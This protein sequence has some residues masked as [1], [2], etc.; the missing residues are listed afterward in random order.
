MINKVTVNKRGS[1]GGD[2]GSGHPPEIC[3]RGGGSC[4]GRGGGSMVI[5]TSLLSFFLARFAR[6]YYTNILHV[7]ILA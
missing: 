3:Q 5:F 2:R 4:V 6:Q 1:R 7:Y